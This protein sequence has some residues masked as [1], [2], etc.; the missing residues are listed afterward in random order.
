M[1]TT[2]SLPSPDSISS[3]AAAWTVIG[4]QT[5][6]LIDAGLVVG[7]AEAHLQVLDLRVSGFSSLY[8]IDD[9]ANGDGS[10]DGPQLTDIVRDNPGALYLESSRGT[11]AL[12]PGPNSPTGVTTRST[13]EPYFW[14]L[15]ANAALSALLAGHQSGDTYTV[16]ISDDQPPAIASPVDFNV[17]ASDAVGSVIRFG[18]AQLIDFDVASADTATGFAF[19]PL[20]LSDYEADDGHTVVFAA[21]LLASGDATFYADAD[22]GGTDAPIAGS[23]RFVGSTVSSILWDGS[24]LTLTDDDDPGSLNIGEYLGESGGGNDLYIIVQTSSGEKFGFDDAGVGFD[25]AEFSDARRGR[26]AIEVATYIDDTN[27]TSSRALFVGLPIATRLILDGI[28][29]GNLFV[30]AASRL[31]AIVAGDA[32]RVSVELSVADAVG[33]RVNDLGATVEDANAISFDM[34]A[35]DATGTSVPV[36]RATANPS[37]IEIEA[38]DAT[39]TVLTQSGNANEVELHVEAGDATGAVSTRLGA[40]NEVELHLEAGDATGFHPVAEGDGNRVDFELRGRSA[41]GFHPQQ[42]GNANLVS[43]RVSTG[44]GVG[45]AMPPPSAPEARGARVRVR[46]A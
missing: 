16:T 9:P 12:I 37:A 38:G 27:S 4:L 13:A 11:S 30:V 46:D 35:G 15:G 44:D 21:L 33:R 23:L 5:N 39:G 31:E 3:T 36:N 41:T 24:T 10:S 28:G 14:R 25:Q 26:V 43:L 40:A 2:I 7:G 8:T 1:A 32:N 18:D 42:S 6:S 29:N 45:V 20:E 19:D 22:R 17:S 34:S